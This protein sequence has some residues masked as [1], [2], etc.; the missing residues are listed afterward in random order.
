MAQSRTTKAALLASAATTAPVVTSAGVVE[1]VPLGGRTYTLAAPLLAE[2]GA[3]LDRQAR[4]GAPTAADLAEAIREAVEE[5]GEGSEAL[6]AYEAAEDEWVSFVNVHV[7]NG[8]DATESIQTQA[9]ELNLAMLKARRARDRVTAR[10][11]RDPRIL[12]IRAE[13][14]MAQWREHCGLVA[15]LLRGWEGE[16]LPPFPGALDGDAVSR[17][18]PMGDVGALAQRAAELMQPTRTA[19]KA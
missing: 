6:D 11:Q 8:P 5:L 1:T 15:L 12:E 13:I 14:Q 18:V 10:V 7:V 3:F 2:V 9:V 16:G 19:G 17:L 4:E